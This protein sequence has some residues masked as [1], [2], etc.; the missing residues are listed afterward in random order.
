MSKYYYDGSEPF[1]PMS[2][3]A[4]VGYSILFIIPV[5]GLILMIVFSLDDNHINRR[6]Y[7]RSYFCWLVLMLIGIV[8]AIATG[9]LNIII[10]SLQQIL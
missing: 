9:S 4:Y 6:N 3:W 2:A 8:V 10:H 5:V 7:A 1:R